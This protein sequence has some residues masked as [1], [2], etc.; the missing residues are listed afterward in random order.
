MAPKMVRL[1]EGPEMG[2]KIYRGP[3][4]I[5]LPVYSWPKQSIVKKA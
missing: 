2:P 1:G 5:L 4:K 3:W